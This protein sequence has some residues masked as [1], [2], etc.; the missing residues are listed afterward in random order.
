MPS[1]PPAHPSDAYF[2]GEMRVLQG[3]VVA[4]LEIAS[5][6]EC[7]PL[8]EQSGAQAA[9]RSIFSQD[10]MAVQARLESQSLDRNI[11]RG[12]FDGDAYVRNEHIA[13]Q[14]SLVTGRAD[15]AAYL[16]GVESSNADQSVHSMGA[17][18][19]VFDGQELE[20]GQ[21]QGGKGGYS[22]SANPVAD[23]GKGT[24]ASGGG[25][26]GGGGAGASGSGAAGWEGAADGYQFTD[27][28]SVYD[29]PEGAY[30]LQE[31]KSIYD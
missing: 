13:V 22:F 6:E 16:A 9:P 19:P 15:N 3:T 10:P 24:M 4:P 1:A 25:G 2:N 12:Q 7:Y 29:E 5:A 31:Y 11:A 18:M 14:R 28:K 26:G 21:G 27:Y 23:A 30:K 20:Q 17:Q 8:A